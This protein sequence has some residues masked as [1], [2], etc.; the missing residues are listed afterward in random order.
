MAN[1]IFAYHGGSGM[2]D[3]PEEGA[4]VMALWAAWYGK[5]GPAI[6]DGG[7]P[8]G[9]SKTVS[10]NGVT[11]DGGSNPISGYTVVSAE[12]IEAAIEMAKGCPILN[13]GTVE[14]APIIEM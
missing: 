7:A 4:R 3:S 12:N 2:P 6:V 9:Q 1:F 8:V 5:L 11:G 14:V 10:A 13:S